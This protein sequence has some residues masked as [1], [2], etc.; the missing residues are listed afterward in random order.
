MSDLVLRRADL[1]DAE[2]L[3]AWR[4][5][6]ATRAASKDQRPLDMETHL[7]WLS[8]VLVDP[9]RNLLIAELDGEAVGTCRADLLENVSVIS[10]TIA[11]ESRGQGVGKRMVHQF[12]SQL[13]G[14]VRAEIRDGNRASSRIAESVGLKLIA[15]KDGFKYFGRLE[16]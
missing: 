9:D 11:P 7:N 5:D 16:I 8:S 12:L 2:R 10:W 4:N 3:F 1:N 6:P 15:E 13:K 14:S